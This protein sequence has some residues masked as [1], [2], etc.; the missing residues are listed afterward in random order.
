MEECRLYALAMSASLQSDL[1]TPETVI[2]EKFLA[3]VSP[4]GCPT[5]IKI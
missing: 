1:S 4:Y 2:A 3:M 5:T